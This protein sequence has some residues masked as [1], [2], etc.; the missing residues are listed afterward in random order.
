VL[1]RVG[2]DLGAIQRNVPELHQARL[3]TKKQ[4]LREQAAQCLQVPLAEIRDGAEIRR[5]ETNN[6]HEIYPFPARLGDPARRVDATA[7]RIKQ[8]HRHHGGVK[9]RLAPL[10]AVGAYDQGEVN[11]FLSQAQHKAG[12][13]VR[14]N[15]VL[16]R[17]WQ[18][19]RLFDLPGAECLAHVPDRI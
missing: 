3:L 18:K 1:R 8:Q 13:M 2:F 5:I 4:N 15:E 9:R 12:Q 19:Q 6:A 14:T 16:H 11:G 17:R 10:A 7:I